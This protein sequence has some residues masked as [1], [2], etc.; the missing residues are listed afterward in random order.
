[1]WLERP[2]RIR[3]DK[4]TDKEM[5]TSK[6]NRFHRRLAAQFRICFSQKEKKQVGWRLRMTLY[7]TTDGEQAENKE[8]PP[9]FTNSKKIKGE[10]RKARE[11]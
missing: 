10:I 1:M 6:R 2:E 8:P 7:S 5:Q 4:F 3:S 11:N 9:R